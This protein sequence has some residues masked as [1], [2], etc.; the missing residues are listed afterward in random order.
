[1]EEL[2]INLESPPPQRAELSEIPVPI[3][4]RVARQLL[5]KSAASQE[6]RMLLKPVNALQDVFLPAHT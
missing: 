4:S 6:R 2:L 3:S 5:I 1:M